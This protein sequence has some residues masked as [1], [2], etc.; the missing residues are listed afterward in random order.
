M[1]PEGNSAHLTIREHENYTGTRCDR[2]RIRNDA[3]AL[4]NEAYYGEGNMIDEFMNAAVEVFGDKVLLQFEDFNSNDAFPLL[5]RTRNTF[6][7]YNDDIQG[8]AAV[9]V[10]GILGA[11]KLKYPKETDLLKRCAMKL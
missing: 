1:D 10:A 7:T 6:L 5:E 4:V 8:T 11:L 2:V 9:T 3:G